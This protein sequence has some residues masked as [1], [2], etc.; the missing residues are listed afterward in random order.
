YEFIGR[1]SSVEAL[2]E[3]RARPHYFDL[4]ITDMVMPDMVGT[5]L[6]RECLRIRP[7]IPVILCTG[8]SEEVTAE[9]VKA[10][11]VR[12]FIMKPI[13]KRQLGAAI[14]QALA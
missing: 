6:A 8:F 13:V 10:I 5:E 3:F 4:V 9:N 2:E 11:G 7:D 12:E 1:T 14:R